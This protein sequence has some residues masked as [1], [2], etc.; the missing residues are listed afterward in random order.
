MVTGDPAVAS[1]GLL[2]EKDSNIGASRSVAV[3]AR[4]TAPDG[5]P[6]SKTA[7]TT[8]AAIHASRRIDRVAQTNLLY[9]VAPG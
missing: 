2:R 5:N 4:E 7:T 6:S 9:T 3:F 8:A 1:Y